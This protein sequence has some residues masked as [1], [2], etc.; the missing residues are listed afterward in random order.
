MSGSERISASRQGKQ[1]RIIIIVSF[2]IRT[3]L[4][5][6]IYLNGYRNVKT[7]LV[8]NILYALDLQSVLMSVEIYKLCFSSNIFLMKMASP[9]VGVVIASSIIEMVFAFNNLFEVVWNV[10]ILIVII[11]CS[12]EKCY[13]FQFLKFLIWLLFRKV[14]LFL[15]L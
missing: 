6:I 2:M 10:N 14:L 5:G 3:I 4:S 13:L 15:L 11:Y 12:N 7:F 8:R 9:C 1:H